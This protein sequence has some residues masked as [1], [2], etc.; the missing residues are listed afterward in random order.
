MSEDGA[1]SFAQ[2]MLASVLVGQLTPAVVARQLCHFGMVWQQLT[3]TEGCRADT[4]DDTRST[5]ELKRIMDDT[6]LGVS[7]LVFLDHSRMP[8]DEDLVVNRWWCNWKA[9]R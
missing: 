4:R 3:N 1:V 6:M 5:A 7:G 8:L 2:L 9:V